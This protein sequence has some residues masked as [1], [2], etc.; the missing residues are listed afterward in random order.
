MREAVRQADVVLVSHHAH[1][2]KGTD[3][4]KPADFIQEFAHFCIDQGAHAYIG[5]GPHILRG[6]EIYHGQPIFYSLGN[7]IFQNDTVESQPHEFYE[8]YDLGSHHTPA[9]AYDAREA[10]GTKGLAADRQVFESVIASF[11]WEGGSTRTIKLHPVTLGFGLTRSRRGKPELASHADAEK[12][13]ED[14]S[15]L[16]APFGTMI[17]NEDGIGRIEIE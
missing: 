16:S 4:S 15:Q 13:L 9:D 17:R 10:G 5:H 6:I 11:E 3:K 1:E 8:N 2:M 12:I 14:L 7:F